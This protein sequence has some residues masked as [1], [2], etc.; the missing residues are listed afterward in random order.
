MDADALLNRFLLSLCAWREGRGESDRGKLLITTTVLNRVADGARWPETIPGVITQH[1][2]FSAFNAG[3][4]NALKFPDDDDPSW[5]ASVAAAD[6]A[7]K[8]IGTGPATR[9]NHY[10]RFDVTPKPKWYDATKIVDREGPHVFLC[11]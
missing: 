9:A 5:A 11:L 2:Q 7:L 1:L 10:L 3:D 8:R 6:E 4:P